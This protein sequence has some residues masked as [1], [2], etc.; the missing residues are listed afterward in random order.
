MAKKRISKLQ[1]RIL[2]TLLQKQDGVYEDV[3]SVNKND[4]V[5]IDALVKADYT[6]TNEYL[7]FKT[8]K[9]TGDLRYVK[10]LPKY[11]I[12]RQKLL[13]NINDW[14][15]YNKYTEECGF[16]S[17]RT[18]YF[19]KGK[20]EGYNKKQTTFTRS[21]Q[22]LA[23]S[24]LIWLLSRFEEPVSVYGRVFASK[25]GV[26]PKTIEEYR[27][28]GLADSKKRYTEAKAQDPTIGTFKDWFNKPIQ[29]S[30]NGIPVGDMTTRNNN[31]LSDYGGLNYRNAKYVRLT[32]KGV[33][34]AE[35][36]LK[37]KYVQHI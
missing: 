21:L 22:T 27:A 4:K 9:P 19:G 15:K 1:K 10:K 3:K 8:K 36:L 20:P 37:V 18:D 34:K 24:N 6:F 5:K 17:L 2:M 30:F 28:K 11:Q 12:R 32:L 23:S 35:E 31:Y 16:A 7:N 25:M 14:Q 13:F 26:I 29:P 33:E